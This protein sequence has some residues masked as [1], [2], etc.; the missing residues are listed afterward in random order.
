MDHTEVI[1]IEYDPEI[2]SFNQLLNLFW[3]NHEYG[4]T[5]KI[6]TQVNIEFF[7]CFNFKRNSLNI[8]SNI[9]LVSKIMKL[10]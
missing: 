7:F 8:C 5:R 1:D 6:K 10:N 3:N 4:L 9:N 2:I